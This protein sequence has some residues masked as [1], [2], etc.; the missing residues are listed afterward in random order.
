[1]MVGGGGRVD[2]GGWRRDSLHAPSPCLLHH[3]RLLWHRSHG[4][5]VVH[6]LNVPIART[7]GGE[8]IVG[9]QVMAMA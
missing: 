5:I 3:L 6:L 8:A 9:A 7:L 4:A 2:D 1:M